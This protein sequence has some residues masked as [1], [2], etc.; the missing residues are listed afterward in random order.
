RYEDVRYSNWTKIPVLFPAVKGLL[1]MII[2]KAKADTI[3]VRTW[4]LKVYDIYFYVIVFLYIPLFLFTLR[5]LI[6]T[7][8]FPDPD[9]PFTIRNLVKY[10]RPVSRQSTEFTR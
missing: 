7:K 4:F 9:I 8:V 6:Q 5:R 3:S 1:N 2:G 10:M